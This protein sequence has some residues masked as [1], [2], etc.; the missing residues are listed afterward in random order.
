[1]RIRRRILRPVKPCIS[2]DIE[3]VIRHFADACVCYHEI[4]GKEGTMKLQNDIDH[5]QEN[6]V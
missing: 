1:M 5:G 6:G 4:K 2:T 3:S